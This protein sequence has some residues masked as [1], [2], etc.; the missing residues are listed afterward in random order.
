MD[1]TSTTS[2]AAAAA[3]TPRSW[4]TNALTTTRDFA[5]SLGKRALDAVILLGVLCYEAF[6]MVMWLLDMK[7]TRI[8]IDFFL[9]AVFLCLLSVLFF[10]VA[11][12]AS[13]AG[14]VR[15]ASDPSSSRHKAMTLL[16][17]TG[18]EFL[19]KAISCVSFWVCQSEGELQSK[20]TSSTVTTFPEQTVK[21]ENQ[22][23]STPVVSK[24]Y[25]MDLLD[26]ALSG[27]QVDISL[28]S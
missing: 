26:N 25:V 14:F 21:T 8:W 22:Q 24:P 19:H 9:Q 5:I 12:V 15:K 27:R 18:F 3:S 2:K 7:L 13:V 1:K 11:V 23:S 16:Q 6:K 17:R 4:A 28:K 20:G 10:N